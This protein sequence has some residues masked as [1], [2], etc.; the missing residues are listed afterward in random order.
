[1]IDAHV[2]FGSVPDTKG[3][4]WGNFNNYLKLSSNIG[5]PKFCVVPIGLP[6][7]F[8]T[9]LTPDNNSV[10]R[11]F[12]RNKSIIPIYWFNVFDLP[13]DIG[14]KY[15]AI[16]FHPDIGKINLDDKRVI[17]FVN[18]FN[19]PIFVH[20]NENKE[21]SSLEKASNLA[22]KVKVPVIAVHSGS[23]T[24]TFFNLDNYKFPDNLYF[25]TSGIQYSIILQKIYQL[26]GAEKIIFGSDYPF[27]DPRVSLSMIDTLETDK[28]EYNLI[29]GGNIKKILNIK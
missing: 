25:E 16:K 20:T 27:G 6:K 23:V 28:N 26:S 3:K 14:I 8:A 17:H 1:M 10:L 22:K 4:N 29:T 18:N 19:L 7:C 13:K 2:H 24:K 5:I 15:K 9:N 12:E 21:Y 11:E